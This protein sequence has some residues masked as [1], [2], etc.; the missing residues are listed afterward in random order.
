MKSTLRNLLLVIAVLAAAS[1]A[2]AFSLWPESL[3]KQPS[4]YVIHGYLDRAPDGEKILDRI[5]I[6][7][8][9]HRRTLLVIWYGTPGETTLDLQL[10]R[11]M[12]QP[13][14]IRGPSDL[15]TRI[16]NAPAGTRIEGKFAAYTSGPPWLLIAEIDFPE[17]QH[18]NNNPP[19]IH[20]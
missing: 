8:D 18:S 3:P 13:F 12:A 10:S 1:T 9:H 17:T 14:E 20:P 11:S 6:T 19:S 7:A 2:R 5:D 15:V 16:G 4:L